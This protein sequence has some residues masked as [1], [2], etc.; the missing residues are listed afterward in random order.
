MKRQFHF[1]LL[2]EIFLLFLLNG[3]YVNSFAIG[4]DE[5]D[6]QGLYNASDHVVILNITN[7]KSHIYNSKSSW[8]VEF[9]S[10]W[11]GHCIRFAPIWKT[12]ASS[13]VCKYSKNSNRIRSN[14]NNL[15]FLFLLC[16]RTNLF[17]YF[18]ITIMYIRVPTNSFL[19]NECLLLTLFTFCQIFQ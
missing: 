16:I 19:C 5:S 2:V 4:M 14:K 10:S 6:N 15:I 9:Y 12:F 7:F 8:M 17:Q 1:I 13:I 18:S 3:K 11:C